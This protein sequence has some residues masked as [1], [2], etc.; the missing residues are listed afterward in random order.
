MASHIYVGGHTTTMH[1]DNTPINVY[2][3]LNN[4]SKLFPPRICLE[5]GVIEANPYP[6]YIYQSNHE[7]LDRAMRDR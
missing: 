3:Q 1:P 2:V 5:D 7:I 4:S 6:L